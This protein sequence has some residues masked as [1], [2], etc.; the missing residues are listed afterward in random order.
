MIA[1]YG[2]LHAA[3]LRVSIPAGL[4]FSSAAPPAVTRSVPATGRRV[5]RGS[6]VV[7]HLASRPAHPAVARGRPRTLTVARFVAAAASTAYSWVRAQKV[8]LTAHLGPLNAGGAPGLLANYRVSRQRPGAGGRLTWGA[9]GGSARGAPVRVPVTVWAAQPAPSAQT[10]SPTATGLTT[11]TVAGTALTYGAP[12]TLY[13]EYG[14]TRRYGFRTPSQLAPMAERA[15]VSASLSGLTPATTYHYRLVAV[16]ARGTSLGADRTFTSSG[17]YQNPVYPAALPDPFVLDNGGSHSDYWVFATG[18]LFPVLHSTDL[19]HWTARGTALAARPKWVTKAANWHP[20]APSVLQTSQACPGTA[21]SRCYVMYYVGLNAALNVNC[22]GVA[23]SPTPGGPYRD[24]GPLALEPGAAASAGSSSTPIGCGDS[25]G[26]GNIDPS[27]FV[28]ASGQGYLYV[29]TDRACSSGSCTLKPTIS[30]IPL[31]AD[32]QHA[33]GSRVPLLSGDPGTWEAAGVP[34]PTVEGPA[35]ELHDGTYYL[36]YSGGSWQGAYGSGYATAPAATGP[37]TKAPANPILAM[38]SAVRT[39]GGGDVPVTGP[40]QGTWLL[41]AG[42]AQTYTAS[43]TLRLDRLSWQA[44]AGGPDAPVI[45]GP[46]T[47]PQAVQP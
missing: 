33:A 1:A 27:P 22:I 43:R 36:F 11:A 25:A 31:A 30:V 37:F 3:G 9:S 7:L 4:T 42:R 32:F 35:V 10:S 26:D 45:A 12:T 21:S 18:N 38:S 5:R 28:D 19:V 13:F 29:S 46:T 40:H 17:Y 15:R 8:A 34:A 2:R 14:T 16:S 47:T 6:V 23:T 44:V 20:W 41:Y 24:Q 39:P